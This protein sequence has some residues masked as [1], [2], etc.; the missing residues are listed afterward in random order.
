MRILFSALLSL[1]IHG[2]VF[3]AVLLGPFQSTKPAVDLDKPVY[4]VELVRPPEPK[5]EPKPEPEPEPKQEVRESEEPAQDEEQAP[6]EERAG[7]RPRAAKTRESPPRDSGAERVPRKSR[8][9]KREP[10]KAQKRP[11]PKRERPRKKPEAPRAPTG[12]K[13]L[14]E[15]LQ[16]LQRDVASEREQARTVAQELENLRKRRSAAQSGDVAPERRKKLYASLVEQRIKQN[17]RFPPVGGDS[18]FVAE[19][20]VRVEASGEIAEYSIVR[21]SGRSDFDDSVLRAV[22]ETGSLPKPPRD[23]NTISITFNLQELRR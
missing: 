23:L 21:G 22:E 13:V 4:E 18:N 15:A 19:V 2:L 7:E 6:E 14:N 8:A 5:P 12:D 9:P 10:K 20:R 3:A 1:L 16:N 17:W 11:D